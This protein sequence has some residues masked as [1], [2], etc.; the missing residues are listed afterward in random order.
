M[1][2]FFISTTNPRLKHSQGEEK[3]MVFN[4]F[5]LTLKVNEK[6]KTFHQRNKRDK[7]NQMNFKQNSY[8]IK[9]ISVFWL[10]GI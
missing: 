9:K 4:V 1:L 5:L 2:T 8:M 10:H 6:K 7:V 3:S